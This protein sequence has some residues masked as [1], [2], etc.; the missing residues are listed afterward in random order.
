MSKNTEHLTKRRFYAKIKQPT[1]TFNIVR[2][3]SRHKIVRK[4]LPYKIQSFLW[5][6][7]LKNKAAK[8]R[9]EIITY[10]KHKTLNPGK[11]KDSIDF[12]KKNVNGFCSINFLKIWICGDEETDRYFDFNGA[13]LPDIS[14]DIVQMKILL[15][16][17]K[18]VFL[19]FCLLNDNYSKILV[20]QFD[21]CMMEGPY[22]YFDTD[23]DVRIKEH[24]IVM[25]VGAWIGD[26]SAYATAKGATAY[27]FE[28]LG[29]NYELLLKTVALNGNK[30]I[31]IKKALGN[32]NGEREIYVNENDTSGSSIYLTK[33]KKKE[34]IEIIT[35][36]EFVEKENIKKIDFI[37]A[38][39]EGEERHL[40]MGAK[41]VLKEFAPK[42]AICTYHSPED[43]E[44]LERIILD[45]N[46]DYCIIHTKQKL[47]ATVKK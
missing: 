5:N 30:I 16:V 32:I 40:L 14:N 42:L 17:F 10:Y 45:A 8:L 4:I 11:M 22:G 25:D 38:D 9:E 2:N 20:E 21:Q 18:D 41:W 34:I 31:P 7:V 24:D 12:L 35:L 29:I 26:F 1:I 46:K 33:S 28:P 15:E 3:I 39:I 44:L 43:P 6:F 19:F 23:F 47:F 37:K 27:T 36:D 13:R